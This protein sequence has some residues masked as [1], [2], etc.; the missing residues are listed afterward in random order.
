MRKA[1]GIGSEEAVSRK[2]SLWRFLE[3]LGQE[4]SLDELV[5]AFDEMT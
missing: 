1:V 5:P 3:Q 2:W 4:P